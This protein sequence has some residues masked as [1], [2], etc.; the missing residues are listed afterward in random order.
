MVLGHA[1]H[2]SDTFGKTIF[3]DVVFTVPPWWT[4]I[5]N[6]MLYVAAKLAGKL[7]I[8]ATKA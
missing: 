8:E 2:I 6:E 5:E 4:P 1:K 3:Y 7:E